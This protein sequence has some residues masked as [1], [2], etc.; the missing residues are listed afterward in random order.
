LRNV[1][2]DLCFA[3]RASTTI[4]SDLIKACPAQQLTSFKIDISLNNNFTD[5]LMKAINLCLRKMTFLENLFLGLSYSNF[6]PLLYDE[7]FVILGGF[8]RLR[9]FK[10]IADHT[11]INEE[12]I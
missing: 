12:S 7:F 5:E 4:V 9:Q 10:L 6:E 8:S 3:Y 2:F 11:E 1:K